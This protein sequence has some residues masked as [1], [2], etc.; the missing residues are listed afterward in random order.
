MAGVPTL[1]LDRA[2]QPAQGASGNPA[3]LFHGVLHPE[4]GAHARLGRAAAWMAQRH[5]GPLIEAGQLAGQAQ[6]LLRLLEDTSPGELQALIDALGLPPEYVQACPAEQVAA[7]LAMPS[8]NP[9]SAC[10][11]MGGGWIDPGAW[12]R[13]ALNRASV[14]FQGG[15]AVHALQRTQAFLQFFNQ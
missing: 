14:Q 10:R 6:G 7:L 12:V 13:W 3:G 1:V 9:M 4:D 8:V 11:F 2:A 5:Y 15:A